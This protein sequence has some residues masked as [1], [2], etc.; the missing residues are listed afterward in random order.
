MNAS[1]HPLLLPA[2]RCLPTHLNLPFDAIHSVHLAWLTF[3]IGIS[4]GFHHSEL[5]FFLNL[6]F[7]SVGQNWKCYSLPQDQ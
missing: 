2:M 4:L 5:E 6:F 1:Q 3:V 7:S